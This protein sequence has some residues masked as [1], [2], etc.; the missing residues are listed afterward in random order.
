MLF[1]YP[2]CCLFT[3]SAVFLYI[4]SA[5]HLSKVLFI[6]QKATPLS[7]ENKNELPA[8]VVSLWTFAYITLSIID[9]RAR[10]IHDSHSC[11]R[12]HNGSIQAHHTKTYPLSCHISENCFMGFVILIENVTGGYFSITIYSPNLWKM[13]FLFDKHSRLT[14]Y[15]LLFCYFGV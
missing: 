10:L 14:Y 8:P 1:I 5:V 3:Q 13:Y 4:N 7:L 9:Y 12:L 2:K 6:I 15:N 11:T